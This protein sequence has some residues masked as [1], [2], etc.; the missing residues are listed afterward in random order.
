[1]KSYSLRKILPVGIAILLFVTPFF[2]LKPGEMDLGGD[3][4]RLYFYQ[5][6]LYLKAHLLYNIIPSGIGGDSLSYF[7]I[8]FV[9]IL[10]FLRLIFSPTILIGIS[11]G[12]K[13]SV[14]FL[15]CYLI[16]K[17]LLS[18]SWK[19]FDAWIIELSAI[20]A[21][22]F[23]VFS[24]IMVNNGWD[25]AIL[26]HT[27]LFVYPLT[28]YLLLRYI[29]SHRFKYLLVLLLFTFFFSFNFSFF[30]APGFF[31]FFPLSVLFLYIYNA[32]VLQKK[33]PWKGIFT[34]AILFVFLQAFQIVPHVLSLLLF[35]SQYNAIFSEEVKITQG[36]DYF[37]AI[38]PS[39][40]V[41]VSLL[42]L[43]QIRDFVWTSIGSVLFPA[44]LICGLIMNRKKNGWSSK[45]TL[46]TF[47]FFLITL[48]FVSANITSFGFNFY[49][50]LFYI[51]GFKMFRNFYGQ[52]ATV[53]V[54]FYAVLIGQCLAVLASGIRNRYRFLLFF[55]FFIALIPGAY[56]LING[57]KVN[58][59]NF[60]SKLIKQNISL[61]VDIDS[62]MQKIR[63]LPV[64]GK[65]LSLPLTGPGYQVI[66]AK[67]GGVYM[68]PSMFSY[69]SG[70]NDFSGYD[71]LGPYGQN[72]IEAVRSSDFSTV[73]RLIS[74]LNIRYIFYNSDPYIYD[75]NFPAFPYDYVRDYMPKTQKEY[76]ALL[77]KLPVDL[78]KIEM[79][80]DKKYLYSI[81]DDSYLPHIYT[82]LNAIYTTF[83][84]SLVLNSQ[85]NK[86]I[87]NAIFYIGNSDKSSDNVTLQ[88][89]PDNPLESLRDNYHLHRHE[90]FV[91][92]K[93]DNYLYPLVLV[94]EKFQLWRSR[95]NHSRYLDFTLYFL[96]KRILELQRWSDM[97]P[98]FNHAVPPPKIGDIFRTNRYFSWEASLSR[99]ESGMS[100][101]IEWIDI[102]KLS[103]SLRD[104][105]KIKIS[106][107]LWQHRNVLTKLLQS[108]RKKD[109]EI[110]YLEAEINRMF[111]RIDKLLKLKEYDPSVLLYNVKIPNISE[112]NK[113]DVFVQNL[114]SDSELALPDLVSDIRLDIN[115]NK[116]KQRIDSKS[117]NLLKLGPVVFTKDGKNPFQVQ[118]QK[119]STYIQGGFWQ[120]SGSISK[121]N[122]VESLSL[123]NTPGDNSGGLVRQIDYWAPK[124]Q[125]VIT[126]NYNTHGDS[127]LFRIFDKRFVNDDKNDIR[128]HVY[129]EHALSANGWATHQAIVTTDLTSLTGY[130]QFLNNTKK[131]DATI[132]IKQLSIVEVTNP[133][134]FFVKQIQDRDNSL[135]EPTVKFSKINSTSYQVEITNAKNPYVL[136]FLEAYN[137]SW[138]LRDITRDSLMWQAKIMRSM[139]RIFTLLSTLIRH[140]VRDEQYI[141]AQYFDG[142][143]LE[144][145]HSNSFLDKRI[146]SSWGKVAVARE[147][148]LRANGYA[149]A[150]IIKPE[151]ME[152]R[153]SYTLIIEMTTQ[154]HFYI[155]LVVSVITTLGIIMYLV[156]ALSRRPVS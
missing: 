14:G 107:Q 47:I 102:N 36:L 65:I 126:F 79:F 129:L 50:T 97:F 106:E 139:G 46:V 60:S 81:S 146:F 136:M 116:L 132:D 21:G 91:S 143:V 8:P 51:P 154:N 42:N 153:S 121:E 59:Y 3:S 16:V 61:D 40:K 27:Q 115:D 57:S 49:K 105:D 141:A 151:D 72:F 155:F 70:K 142:A 114:Q 100:S 150:W 104:A 125:F 41:S 58:D 38:A 31:S 118:L 4:S 82:T 18:Y 93:L 10:A 32:S 55:L 131:A 67:N 145:K 53:Y 96:T 69:L 95:K 15:A 98:I 94:K 68:G 103:D 43:A 71:S 37:T 76:L 80:W 134:I 56:P 24:P 54:F 135:K 48:F 128:R 29:I 110:Q 148:H 74:L 112:N 108:S 66:A 12:L 122:T 1:M 147:S 34:G 133:K 149:N 11:N 75:D 87:K 127:V 117:P 137:D 84:D 2:W 7:A 119:Q 73:D 124:K 113:Y 22:L 30:S 156:F 17:E 120:T 33:F 99:Y 13:L 28:F 63:Q 35:K 138:R 20:A 9:M 19:N 101:I 64:D 85:L 52:W 62:L 144:G 123:I 44:V 140:D 77:P 92:V 26:T 39:I 88:A 6:L 45:S 5:P 25:R 83:P 111:D 78:N 130:I 152:N 90:P 89:E 109:T 23:Y 86:D